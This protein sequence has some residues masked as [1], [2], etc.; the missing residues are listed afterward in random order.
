VPLAIAICMSILTALTAE[1]PR[2]RRLEFDPAAGDWVETPPP[3]PGTAEGDLHVIRVLVQEGKYRRAISAIRKFEKRYGK[4]DPLYPELMVVEAAAWVARRNYDKAGQLLTAFFNEFAGMSI[5]S[6]AMRLKFVIAEAYLAGA[7]RRFLGIPLFSGEDAGFAMLDEI[8][9]D[10]AEGS[11]AALAIKTKG[12][13]LFRTG[14]HDLAELEYARLLRDHPQSRY[15]PFALRRSAD[16]ALASFAGVEYD[17]AALIE[18]QERFNDYLARFRVAAEQEGVG[19][20]LD[21]IRERRAE[22]DYQIGTYYER[23]DHLGSAVFYYRLV[24]QEWPDT[25]AATRA[26]QRLVLL[27]AADETHSGT[28]S[29]TNAPESGR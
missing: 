9:T 2:T 28:A 18:A 13:H 4:Q 12:D 26:R 24:L 6:E 15:Y 16:A 19:L 14:E 8:V 21:T 7:K 17:E 22:K 20:I 11:V 5:A 27:G 3:P 25:V 29:E 23:T 1:P 10:D